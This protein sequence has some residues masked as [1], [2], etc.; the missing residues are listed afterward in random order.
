[1]DHLPV[2]QVD[3]GMTNGAPSLPEEEQI[4]RLQLGTIQLMSHDLAHPGL[5]GAGAG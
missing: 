1:M 4:T 5:F 2:A 3:A